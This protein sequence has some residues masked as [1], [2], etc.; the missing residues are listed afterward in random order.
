[1]KINTGFALSFFEKWI[2]INMKFA[3]WFEKK[4]LHD[5][6]YYETKKWIPLGSLQE[7]C[8]QKLPFDLKKQSIDYINPSIRFDYIRKHCASIIVS[9][10]L[11]SW[12]YFHKIQKDQNLQL[13]YK[14]YHTDTTTC[15]YIPSHFKL[16]TIYEIIK[17]NKWCILH[18]DSMFSKCISILF[19]FWLSNPFVLS[20]F[21]SLFII[22]IFQMKPFITM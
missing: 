9:T 7:L 3:N 6:C 17:K 16:E 21:F 14:S 5:E 18:K 10:F 22:D 4:F 15:L 13:K 2:N 20:I 1:M 19:F 12:I 11:K 8:F